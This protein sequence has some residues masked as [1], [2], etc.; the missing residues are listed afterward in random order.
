MVGDGLRILHVEDQATDAELIRIHL[1]RTRP[2][3]H[4][5]CVTSLADVEAALVAPSQPRAGPHDLAVPSGLA[6]D[7]AM[8]SLVGGGFWG[9]AV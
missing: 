5:D 7:G 2:G 4:I 8:F 9:V 3:W 6:H 1:G